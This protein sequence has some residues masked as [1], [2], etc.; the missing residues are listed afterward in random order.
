MIL[1]GREFLLAGGR[2]TFA[3]WQTL[4]AEQQAT[5]AKAGELVLRELA[6]MIAHTI[7]EVAGEQNDADLEAWVDK[8]VAEV[9]T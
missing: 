3:E 4:S 8:V 2:I 1:P 5:L 9:T 6:D 7:I